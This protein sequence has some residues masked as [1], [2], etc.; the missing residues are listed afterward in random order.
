M[1]LSEVKDS[2]AFGAELFKESDESVQVRGSVCMVFA[3][4]DDL[5]AF[6]GRF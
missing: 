2:L 4:Y 5:G 3:A 6:E 1:E